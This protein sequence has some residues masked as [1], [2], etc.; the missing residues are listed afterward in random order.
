MDL[1]SFH[2]GSLWE[3]F[4]LD[5]FTSRAVMNFGTVAW[6]HVRGTTMK[7]YCI[8]VQKIFCIVCMYVCIHFDKIHVQFSIVKY[9]SRIA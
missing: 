8:H 7:R 3:N 5:S 2:N 4:T 6:W 1:F 9:K